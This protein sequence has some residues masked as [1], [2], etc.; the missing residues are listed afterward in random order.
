MRPTVTMKAGLP[1]PSTSRAEAT[2]A[3]EVGTWDGKS[4]GQAATVLRSLED[5]EEREARVLLGVRVFEALHEVEH[6]E[7]EARV[8]GGDGRDDPALDLDLD[9]DL[10]PAREKKTPPRRGGHFGSMMEVR[11]LSTLLLQARA[12]GWLGVT[13]LM[14]ALA[15]AVARRLPEMSSRPLAV[16]ASHHDVLARHLEGGEIEVVGSSVGED[17]NSKR[18]L[19]QDQER[20][21][22]RDG[23]FEPTSSSRSVS[24]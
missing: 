2:S 12:L 15:R 19:D 22:D 24:W 18:Y 20:D 3:P 4:L 13:P 8:D 5:G 21:Q 10:D 6:A 11:T 7:A 16:A 17:Q 23:V 14:A 9:L 1:S